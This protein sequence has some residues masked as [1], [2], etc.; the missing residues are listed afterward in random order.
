MLPALTTD[1]L[2]PPGIHAAEW[3]D[4]RAR[5]A[6][7]PRRRVLLDGFRDACVALGSA[8]CSTVWI[9]GSF[10]TD[11]DL[12]GDYDACWDWQGVDP[13]KLDPVLLDF[14]RSGRLLMKVKYSG[15]LFVAGATEG[16]SGLAF[17]DFFQQTR[18]GE[19][20]GIVSLDPRMVP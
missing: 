5:F 3:S 8:G 14:S 9:D 16:A 19:A 15:D 7:N 10:V 18:N 13:T 12:P 11:K 17:V 20:K 1:G 4:L 6:H 2:L